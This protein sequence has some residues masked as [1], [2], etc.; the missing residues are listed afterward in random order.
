MLPISR[1]HRDISISQMGVI[2]AC[3]S[4]IQEWKKLLAA[5][6]ERSGGGGYT[7]DFGEYNAVFFCKNFLEILENLLDKLQI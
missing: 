3:N 1:M 7:D 4:F 5:I 6:V 2:G